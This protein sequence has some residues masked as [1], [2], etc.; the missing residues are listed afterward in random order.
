MSAWVLVTGGAA[1]LGREIGLTFAKAKWNLICHYRNS[2]SE[3]LKLCAEAMSHGVK[4]HALHAELESEESC[5]ELYR[6]AVQ[7]SNSELT[8]I[9]NNASLF[10][11]DNAHDFEETQALQQ[12]SVN[13]VAPMR[14]GK[15]FYSTLLDS[16]H[17][18]TKGRQHSPS[19]VHI[20]DQKVF[21]LNP[22]YF[23]YTV[24][25]LALER[26][27]ALQAQSFGAHLRVNAVSPGLLYP[28][29]P[30]NLENFQAASRANLMGETIS[31]EQVAKSALFLAENSC[32]TGTT[33]Q[34]DNGQHLVPSARDIMFVTEKLLTHKE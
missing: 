25:K 2:E 3:A 18:S 28:S 8:C 22:D 13:L 17:A 10:M 14:F 1:R 15:W 24:S 20:L 7:V 27:V 12:L 16:K 19:M 31:A 34:V 5:R 11:P 26:I 23:S 6:R 30:Q 21:N 29:G 33:L 4:A 32:I 9:I